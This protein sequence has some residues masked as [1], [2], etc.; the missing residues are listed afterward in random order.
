C[1]R[2]LA[3][4]AHARAAAGLRA[5]GATLLA[6]RHARAAAE[7][8]ERCAATLAPAERDVFA[9]HP[10]RAIAERD[11]PRVEAT[12]G[13]RAHKLERLVAINRRL[14]TSLDPT[15]VLSWTLDSALELTLADR[16]FLLLLRADGELDVALTRNADPGAA[17]HL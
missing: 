2:L 4:E 6:E 13:G 10:A 15:T 17:D 3:A 16:G 1:Q 7:L 9:R 14:S 8:L 11:A 12:T 5:N